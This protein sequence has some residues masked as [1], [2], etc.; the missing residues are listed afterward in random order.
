MTGGSLL[1]TKPCSPACQSCDFTSLS[2]GSPAVGPAR[3]LHPEAA[4]GTQRRGCPRHSGAGSRSLGNH[5][6]SHSLSAYVLG[7]DLLFCFVFGFFVAA[8]CSLR[9]LSSLSRD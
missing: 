5:L 3:V 2:L 4:V 1:G 7:Q 9:E 6:S 8:P